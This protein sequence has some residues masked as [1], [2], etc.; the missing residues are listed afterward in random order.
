MEEKRR[1]R[2]PS[3]A[4]KALWLRRS[5][6]LGLWLAA[7]LVLAAAALLYY[8]GT[9]APAEVPVRQGPYFEQT[10]DKVNLNQA[11]LCELM[12]LPGI[13]EKRGQAIIA[14]RQRNGRITELEQLLEIS[15]IGPKT[16]EGLRPYACL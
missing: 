10:E 2:K 6:L 5:F 9:T 12:L 14:Y 15:G 13:G 3:Q 11:P 7:L 4:G 1:A 16:L 8:P